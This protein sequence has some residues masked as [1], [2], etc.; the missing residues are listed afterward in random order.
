MTDKKKEAFNK[1]VSILKKIYGDDMIA[2][3]TLIRGESEENVSMIT[4][5][6][7]CVSDYINGLVDTLDG[8]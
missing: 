1:A 7:D 8:E 4:D 5:F 6:L 3:G 2:V